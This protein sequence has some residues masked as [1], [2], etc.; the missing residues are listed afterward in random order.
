MPCIHTQAEG[1]AGQ[2]RIGG[3]QQCFHLFFSVSSIA[4]QNM[5]M[6]LDLPV[7]KMMNLEDVVP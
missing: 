1:N 2:T 6:I 5:Q 7:S 4:D 3:K